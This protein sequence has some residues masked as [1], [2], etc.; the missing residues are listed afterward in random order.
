MKLTAEMQQ[1][2]AWGRG[3]GREPAWVA[4]RSTAVFPRV[5]DTRSP[6]VVYKESM[7]LCDCPPCALHQRRGEERWERRGGE[8]MIPSDTLKPLQHGTDIPVSGGSRACV[9][10]TLVW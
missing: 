8:Q 7:V 5:L 2:N 9:I 3:G 1:G 10:G 4:E 6:A